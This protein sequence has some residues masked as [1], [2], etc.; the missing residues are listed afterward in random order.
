MQ[1]N[2]EELTRAMVRRAIEGKIKSRV[3]DEVNRFADEHEEWLHETVQEEA[4]RVLEI[5]EPIEPEFKSVSEFVDLFVRPMYPTTAAT[6][7]R[8]NWS[9][10][11]FEHGEAM[12]RLHAM[13]VKY[14]AMRRKDEQGFLEEYL[15][16]HADYHMRQL[17]KDDGVFA[18]CS[19]QDVES[20]PLPSAH[21]TPEAAE[22]E[23]T[24][25]QAGE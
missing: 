13:W 7:E 23:P 2:V 12:A 15:R 5:V 21:D 14:E 9:A 22:K 4:R 1:N 24:E 17:M 19:A 16:V 18:E 10:R 6:V 8:T 20:V 11:W 25:N 3:L